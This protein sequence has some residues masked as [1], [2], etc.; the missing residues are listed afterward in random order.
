[1]MDRPV[2]QRELERL[3]DMAARFSQ[4][5]RRV[6]TLRKVY[7]FSHEEI[8]KHLGMPREAV[9]KHLIEAARECAHFLADA[10]APRA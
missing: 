3:A 7:G 1:M 8:A 4:P 9:E 2:K 10:P 5:M 6:F